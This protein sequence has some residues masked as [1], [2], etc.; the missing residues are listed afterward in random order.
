MLFAIVN[1][2]AVEVIQITDKKKNERCPSDTNEQH[3]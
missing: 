1:S 3:S 2:E